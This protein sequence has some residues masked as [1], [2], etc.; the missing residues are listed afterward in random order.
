MGLALADRLDLDFVE[1]TGRLFP[2]TGNERDGCSL[3]EE[4]RGGGD[5]GKPEAGLAGDEFEMG[6]EGGFGSGI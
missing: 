4:F 2:V 1:L 5:G 6:L 3:G